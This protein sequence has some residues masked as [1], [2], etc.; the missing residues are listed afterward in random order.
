MLRTVSRPCARLWAAGL[1]LF[2]AFGLSGCGYN[3]FQTLDE[4]VK[5]SWPKC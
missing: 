5:G 4:Q 3:N 2:A 1:A